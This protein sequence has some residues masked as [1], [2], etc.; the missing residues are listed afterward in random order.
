[1]SPAEQLVGV[2]ADGVRGGW[3]VATCRVD[4]AVWRQAVS[5][6]QL[7]A[8]ATRR[9]EFQRGDDVAAIAELRNGSEAIVAIDVPLGV[10]EHG[11]ARPCDT[12]ARG[13]LD[14]GHS[15]V[16]SPPAQYLF[17]ALAKTTSGERWLEVQRLVEERRTAHPQE[18]IPGVTQQTVGIL[19][20]VADADAFLHAN[21]DAQ[22]WLIECHPEV[23]FL[24]LNEGTLLA[25]KGSGKGVLDRLALIER[26]FPGVTDTLREHNVAGSVPLADLLDACAALWTALRVGAGVIHPERGA[27]GCEP[28]GR[29]PRADGLILR[30][31]A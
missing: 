8:P 1:M 24:R 12:A 26:E 18:L 21:L 28:G 11:G 5:A 25:P 9:V 30:I 19:D 15:S 27:L 4:E 20:K 2:G 7:P 14:K 6:A 23:S 10:L 31:V 16:F 3:V 13:L 17:P 29:C 22:A